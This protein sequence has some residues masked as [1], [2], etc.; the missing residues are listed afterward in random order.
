MFMRGQMEAPRSSSNAK[1]WQVAASGASPPPSLLTPPL[2]AN[3][4]A[5]ALTPPSTGFNV[6]RPLSRP[7]FIRSGR[8]PRRAL[9]IPAAC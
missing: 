5:K 2:Q 8:T 1:R 6:F 3:R 9:L 4:P 7:V